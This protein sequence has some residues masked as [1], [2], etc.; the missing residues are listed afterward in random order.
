MHQVDS[1][2]EVI[3]GS[4]AGTKSTL[5]DLLETLKKLE[6]EEHLEPPKPERKNAWCKSYG[7]FLIIEIN[8]Y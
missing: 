3:P 8:V 4:E 6:E 7:P 1:H 2:R 5:N